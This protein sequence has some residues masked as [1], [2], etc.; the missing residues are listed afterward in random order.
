LGRKTKIA[1]FTGIV[2]ILL[3][4]VGAYAYDSSQKDKIADGVTIGGV[5][6]GGMGTAEAK[7]AIRSQLLAPLKNSLRVGYDGES[8]ELPGKKLKIH[9]DLDAAVEEALDRSSDGG[10]PGRLVRYVTGGEL[11]DRISADVSYSQ[12]AVNR[13]VREIADEVDR[14]MMPSLDWVKLEHVSEVLLYS[15]YAMAPAGNSKAF[16]VSVPGPGVQVP[17]RG[18]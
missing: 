15:W 18:R 6:V 8:W 12:P 4:A 13:F 1:L 2:V 10:L 3:G 5:D 7:R 16:E 14:S 17:L 11:D 9:A